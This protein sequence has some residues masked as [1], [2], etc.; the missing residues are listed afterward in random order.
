VC[1]DLNF[2]GG[3]VKVRG[4]RQFAVKRDFLF[5]RAKSLQVLT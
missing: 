3:A 1:G 4:E 2:D 5:G